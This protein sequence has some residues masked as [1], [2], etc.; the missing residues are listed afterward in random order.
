MTLT[1]TI[2]GTGTLRVERADIEVTSGMP[3]P[4]PSWTHIDQHGHT[5]TWTDHDLPT[6]R[7]IVDERAWCA[8]CNDWHEEGH[9]E[10]QQC[11]ERVEPVMR[12]PSSFREFMPGLTDYYLNDEPIAEETAMRLLDEAKGKKR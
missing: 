3:R 7:W 5:H 10:C 12:G 1:Y 2:V 4:D 9:Y 8:S 6:L 11:G